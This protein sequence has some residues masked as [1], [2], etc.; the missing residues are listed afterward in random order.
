MMSRP[1]MPRP[2]AVL[3][4]VV[5]AAALPHAAAQYRE[6]AL[7]RL[8]TTPEERMSRERNR[9][10]TPAVST[11]TSAPPLT[12]PATLAPPIAPPAPVRLTGVV[13]RSDGRATIWI[14][15]EPHQTTLR[16]YRPGNPVS[17]DTPAGTVLVKP[18]QSY[19]PNNGAV[20]NPR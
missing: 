18:G 9:D 11:E 12:D 5:A 17:I 4:A 8:F 6:P 15:D 10:T 2:L 3:L 13:R 1:A 7:G 19:D 16:R 14:D 20:R